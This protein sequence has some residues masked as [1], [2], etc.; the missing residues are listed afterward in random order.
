MNLNE[1]VSL[2]LFY[3]RNA[4]LTVSQTTLSPVPY[5][6]KDAVTGEVKLAAVMVWSVTGGAGFHSVVVSST[7]NAA[8][9]YDYAIWCGD[10][11]LEGKLKSHEE[12]ISAIAGELA[13]MKHRASLESAFGMIDRNDPCNF[14]PNWKKNQKLCKHTAAVVLDFDMTTIAGLLDNALNDFTKTIYNGLPDSLS[15]IFGFPPATITTT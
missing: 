8:G 1:L 4:A 3:Q 11:F 14:W 15:W 5:P 13:T 9:D 2:R 10:A 6:Y 12:R 7:R